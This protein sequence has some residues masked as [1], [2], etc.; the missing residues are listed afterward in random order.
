MRYVWRNS[1][2]STTNSQ[3][4]GKLAK[5]GWQAMG[6]DWA[7]EAV[8]LANKTAQVNGRVNQPIVASLP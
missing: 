8:R 3:Q 5:S 1:Q 6:V 7:E 4:E 2:Q